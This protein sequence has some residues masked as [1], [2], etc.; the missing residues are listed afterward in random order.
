MVKT[1]RLSFKLKGNQADTVYF[2]LTLR[3]ADKKFRNSP[4]AKPSICMTGL[5]QSQ[6]KKIKDSRAV[7]AANSQNILGNAKMASIVA[8]YI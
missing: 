2:K 8:N 7:K 3:L 6:I 4:I 1:D 5:S